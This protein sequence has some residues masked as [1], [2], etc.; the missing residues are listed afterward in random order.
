MRSFLG[1]PIMLRGVAYGNLY[2]TEKQGGDFTDEDEEL[3]ALL[4]AQAAVA[5][6][7]ARLYESATAWSQQLESLNEVGAALVG[8]LELGPLLDLVVRRLRELIA[9]RL[10]AIALPS[11]GALRIAAADGTGADALAAFDSLERDSKTS[12]VLERG[13]SERVDS[14]L[15]DPEVDQDVARRLGASTG[16]YVPLRARDRTIGVLIAHDK[17][18]RDLRFSSG[19]LR[20]AEQ[21]ALRASIAVD[22]SQR[23]ARDSLR[24]VVAGQ[25]VERRRLARELHDET[26]QALTSI[27]LGLRALEDANTGVDVDELR[28]L[29]VATLHD[30]RRLAVQ[31]RPKALDD[32]GLVAALERLAQTFSE[33]SGIRVQLEAQVGDERLPPE[34]ETTVYRIVQE[35]LTNVV[36]HAEATEVSILLMRRDG[37]L[38]AV[39]EDNGGGFEPEAVRSDTLGLEGMRERV[40][41]HDGRLTLE[42][43]PGAGTTLR[44]E[45]PL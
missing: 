10:V 17:I 18:G 41:L 31:L 29:V 16:L 13:R 28:E 15:E 43:S 23:V 4:A 9:A 24:R 22:L 11:G 6:E 44:V 5:V 26:G 40:A 33:S 21:F 35:A 3:L 20:I 32:F 12:R 38:T 25:E 7:N 36:K 14:L 42:S 2:L 34:V 37:E 39:L 19:D 45:V 30:V 1:V 8:E 27:L